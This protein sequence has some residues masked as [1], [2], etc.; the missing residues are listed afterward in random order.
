MAGR[1]HQTPIRFLACDA[2]G[3]GRCRHGSLADLRPKAPAIQNLRDALRKLFRKKAAVVSDDYRGRCMP[4]VI[5][6]VRSKS[7]RYAAHIRERKFFRHDA[8][9]TICPEPD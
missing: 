4:R 2:D 6:R 3:K 5:L 8:P 7:Q 9:P 1:D